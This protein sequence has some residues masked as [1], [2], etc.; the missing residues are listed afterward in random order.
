MATVHRRREI[1][2]KFG[3]WFD[4]SDAKILSKM[5]DFDD[6]EGV[7]EPVLYDDEEDEEA[8][9]EVSYFN[10]VCISENCFEYLS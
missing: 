8:E 1:L 5:S 4:D 7:D 3:I 6:E 2:W 9:E 10:T